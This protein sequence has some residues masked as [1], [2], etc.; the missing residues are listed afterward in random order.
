MLAICQILS[1][2]VLLS[3]FAISAIGNVVGPIIARYQRQSFSL[4]PL[5]G[6]LAGAV[7]CAIAPWDWLRPWWWVAPIVDIGC[8]PALTAFAIGRS[9]GRLK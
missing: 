2:S 8:L 6:G 5:I 7:G 3:I 4:V 1:A 9:T